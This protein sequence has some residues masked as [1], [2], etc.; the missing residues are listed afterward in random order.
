[1]QMNKNI[2]STYCMCLTDRRGA[3]T[4][5]NTPHN[6]PPSQK[7]KGSVGRVKS[8]H[9]LTA[10]QEQHREILGEAEIPQ[11]SPAKPV[12]KPGSPSDLRLGLQPRGGRMPP[13]PPPRGRGLCSR[14]LFAPGSQPG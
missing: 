10:R 12:S 11:L 1:M 8:S 7:K 4:D 9:S 3:E 14:G 5:Q 2:L 6:P 13:P